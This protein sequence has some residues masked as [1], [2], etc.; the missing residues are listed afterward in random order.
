MQ[1]RD[2]G[3]IK[4]WL[5]LAPIP[6]A[7]RT[8]DGASQALDHEQIPGEGAL[9]ARAG[10]RVKV[11][12]GE[13]IWGALPQE[14]YLIDFNHV[15]GEPTDYSVKPTDY[16]VAYAITYIR[17]VGDQT[18]LLMQVFSD[19]QAKVYL[20]GKELD[21]S[22]SLHYKPAAD[23]IKGVEL[24]A[25]LNVLV[26]KVVNLNGPWLGSVW[27]SDAAGRPVKGITVTLDPGEPNRP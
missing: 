2:P 14:D 21:R 16:S 27:F 17:S 24:K 11:G 23:L 22:N 20:N 15:L 10:D 6:F 13:L 12:A 7:D 19:D 18:G 25:G 9:R 4:Q 5:V 3:A 26:F 1:T 8:E